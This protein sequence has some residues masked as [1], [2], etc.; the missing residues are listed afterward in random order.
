MTQSDGGRAHP[1]VRARAL[2]DVEMD[3]RSDG[4][5]R[6]MTKSDL[7]GCPSA[8][9]ILGTTRQARRIFDPDANERQEKTGTGGTTDGRS[10]ILGAS[11]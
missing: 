1:R 4:R 3:C 8:P 7:R 10:S 9:L 11:L 5:D 6:P 2:V